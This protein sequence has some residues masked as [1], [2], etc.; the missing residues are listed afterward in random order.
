MLAFFLKPF[1]DYAE[2]HLPPALYDT[3]KA[4]ITGLSAVYL[5]ISQYLPEELQLHSIL[6]ALISL[7]TLFLAIRS[8]YR[9]TLFAIRTAWFMLKWSVVVG[10]IAY[11]F[12]GPQVGGALQH[13]VGGLGQAGRQFGFGMGPGAAYDMG[14]WLDAWLT[15]PTS[16]PRR[17]TRART[18]RQAK[19]KSKRPL[20][21]GQPPT[22]FDSFD[23]HKAYAERVR[24]RARTEAQERTE[25]AY[26]EEGGNIEQIY[27]QVQ[28]AWTDN[29]KRW[30]ETFGRLAGFTNNEG[31]GRADSGRRSKQGTGRS[32]AR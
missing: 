6:P 4:L 3:L 24:A 12:G 9:S 18:T 26:G 1:A 17:K 5:Y 21:A 20:R 2:A 7:I 10:A 27:Q 29:G 16:S 22:V 32:K 8:A 25:P 15:S 11:L 19:A 14:T 23:A 30:W 31:E 28:D 13:L